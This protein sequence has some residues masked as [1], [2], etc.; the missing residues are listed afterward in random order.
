MNAKFFDRLRQN[1]V[2][3]FLCSHLLTLLLV[4]LVC[5]L[6]FQSA[7]AIVRQDIINSTRFALSQSVYAVDNA[8]AEMRTLGLQLSG[9]TNLRKLAQT[10]VEDGDY[11]YVARQA[12]DG[13]TNTLSYYAS[14]DTFNTYIYLNTRQRV[15]YRDSIYRPE[16]F[17]QYLR[18]WEIGIDEWTS[19]CEADDPSPHFSVTAN[20]DIH[21]I[22]P[23]RSSLKSDQNMAAVVFRIDPASLLQNMHFLSSYEHYTLLI[24]D[25]QGKMLFTRDDLGIAAQAA[26]EWWG[27]ALRSSGTNLVVAQT[28]SGEEGLQFL[29]ILP[30]QTTMARLTALHRQT[31]VLIL[32]AGVLGIVVSLYFSMRS[33]RPVNEIA[34]ALSGD[35][36]RISVDLD[37]ISGAVGQM[38]K[39]NEHLL[40]Q[41]EQDLPALQK[42][43]FHNLL[44]SD[45]LSDAEMR[46]MAQRAQ[47]EL[48][49]KTYCAALLRL[50][51]QVDVDAIDGQTVED[52]RILQQAIGQ[53]I[54]RRCARPVWNY[55]RNT[56][57]TL[58][59][60]EIQDQQRL[61]EVI[62]GV[63][64]WLRSKY[65][66]EAR[67]GVGTPCDD[68]MQFWKSS[69]EA[70]SAL[71]DVDLEPVQVY[72]GNRAAHDSYYF[73]YAVE[74]RLV[75]GLR[76]GD[77]EVV[78]NALALVQQENF[79]RRS[80]SRAQFQKVNRRI[81]D[82][83]SA[84]MG[85]S[86]ED[87]P[88][89]MRLNALVF[90]YK[91]EC[92]AYFE[93]LNDLC[94]NLCE[95]VA[96]QK[97]AR[98]SENVQAIEEY[99]RNNYQD[100]G[101][102]LGKVSA[103]FNLSEGYLSAIFKR[104]TGT[105]F[106]EYLEQLR[107]RNACALL[108]AGMKVTEVAERVG[109]NSIQSFR[110]AFKRVMGVSPSEYRG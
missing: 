77:L 44:K 26:D 51:P 39:D 98:R 109:Y 27:D 23:S 30:E 24:R 60:F 6:G 105:N 101:L 40:R 14:G 5:T 63:T 79:V 11:Y 89:L 69:E 82:I 15:I 48:T 49:G 1:S 18:G 67:W 107:V 53:E 73:P 78:S 42:T 12:V 62:R 34:R 28:G 81:M 22:F 86:V 16:I 50:F 84:Q 4:L 52:A 8:L 95:N 97:S 43:F 91:G 80:L 71:N 61:L 41:Q 19:M 56:L 45:F 32:L 46:Y 90:N 57:S 93:A 38:L 54:D 72:D 59:I 31:A 2:V 33:G 83:L 106:A 87:S 36:E 58:Y 102:G 47:V 66:V 13:Y 17:A 37:Q 92:E 88:E 75:Q 9:S 85:V 68:L 103:E 10:S 108:S 25:K 110:R 21:Y 64:G 74:D 96:R 99:L 55:K 20:G 70:G 100:S 76:A 35:G 94:Q 104:E 29:L 65:N 7:F 3:R